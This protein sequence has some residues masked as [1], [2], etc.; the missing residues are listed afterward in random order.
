MGQR[1]LD[2]V[3]DEEHG[4]KPVMIQNLNQ[5]YSFCWVSLQAGAHQAAALF[6]QARLGP[7]VKVDEVMVMGVRKSPTHKGKQ[8]HP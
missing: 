6:R 2:W 7:N 5:I 3:S 4:L 1:L 8:K